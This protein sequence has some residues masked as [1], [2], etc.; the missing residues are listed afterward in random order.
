MKYGVEGVFATP[1]YLA[2]ID[3]QDEIT[4]EFL[5]VINK[6]RFFDANEG[7]GKPQKLTTQNFQDNVIDEN[8]MCIIKKVI[9]EN[10]SL[11]LETLN[12]P[13]LQY[14]LTSWITSNDKGQYSP[15]HNHLHADISGVYYYQTNK[16]DGNIFFLTPTLAM[17]SS[18]FSKLANNYYIE[19]EE[20][21]LIMF[22][23]WL[24]HGVTT[25]NTENNRKSLAFNIYF[26]R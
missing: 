16:K 14:N 5:A 6:L 3:K 1:L 8:N 24:Q 10:L 12:L 13:K 2:M 25:N 11:F 22:P 23:G 7:W 15:V 17:T 18:I 20:G 21:K 26:K 4:S 19:P 9:D